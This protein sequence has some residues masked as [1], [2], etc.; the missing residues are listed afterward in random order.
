MKSIFGLVVY[1]GMWAVNNFIRNFLSTMGWQT[2][3]YLDIVFCRLQKIAIDLK[4]F[5]CLFAHLFLCLL[6][7]ANPGVRIK[8]VCLFSSFFWVLIEMNQVISLCHLF[9]FGNK[10]RGE[11]ISLG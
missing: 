8:N 4:I 6:S 2:V 11:F 5:E 3:H 9:G 7:H 1:D 10:I